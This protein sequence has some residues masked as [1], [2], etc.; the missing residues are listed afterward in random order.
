MDKPPKR[1]VFFLRWNMW[2]LHEG[3]CLEIMPTLPDK[4]VDLVL[5]DP[6]YGIDFSTNYR[7]V[8]T[9]ATQCG[10]A[11]DKDNAG[12]LR[13]AIKEC[14]RVLKD[15]SHFYWFTRWDKI[16]EQMPMIAEHFTVKNVLC[17]VKDNWSMGDLYG[18]YANQYECIVFAQKGSRKLNRVAG[19]DRH[20][21]IIKVPR[22][23]NQTMFHNHQKPLA[24][25][26]LLLL[27]STNPGETILD[28]FAGSG[29]TLLAAIQND[30]R[31]IG[32]E[33]SHE[34]CDIIRKRLHDYENA[35]QEALFL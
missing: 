15:D 23:N 20:S 9:I 6:P 4:S 18:A 3:D 13:A 5:T 30:R 25:L 34:Y 2:T 12:V 21:D 35:R 10:I 17:W 24:L 32:C 27:K 1:A 31:S 19:N 26:Q 28:P 7:K 11:N 14:F 29:S 22:V 16:P 8:N 33:L